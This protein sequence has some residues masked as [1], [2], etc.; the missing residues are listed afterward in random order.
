MTTIKILVG[1][2]L[3]VLTSPFLHSM[4]QS[5]TLSNYIELK[6]FFLEGAAICLDKKS[7]PKHFIGLVRHLK[8]DAV[9]QALGVD[10]QILTTYFNA[11]AVVELLELCTKEGKHERKADALI[12]S[13]KLDVFEREFGSVHI[14]KAI[15]Q[16]AKLCFFSG[17][18]DEK[19]E[20]LGKCKESVELLQQEGSEKLKGLVRLEKIQKLI[21]EAIAGTPFEWDELISALVIE[22][23]TV[24]PYFHLGN[25]LHLIKCLLQKESLT[26]MILINSIRWDTFLLALPELCGL[27]ERL[28]TGLFDK[29]LLEEQLKRFQNNQPLD[30]LALRNTIKPE[31][32]QRL[33]INPESV[34][35]YIDF[36]KVASG[37]AKLRNNLPAPELREVCNF[38]RI[39][40]QTGLDIQ[41][42]FNRDVPEQVKLCQLDSLTQVLTNR[43]FLRNCKLVLLGATSTAVLWLLCHEVSHEWME[44]FEPT[45][46]YT[47]WPACMLL[48]YLF[49]R[50]AHSLD[51]LPT[52]K[53]VS[54]NLALIKAGYMIKKQLGSLPTTHQTVL[55]SVPQDNPA[56]ESI[57]Q[58]L[59]LITPDQLLTLSHPCCILMLFENPSTFITKQE[60]FIECICSTD[61]GNIQKRVAVIVGILEAQSPYN[62]LPHA[63]SFT[64]FK[65]LLGIM[66]TVYDKLPHKKVMKL[67]K[68]RP[69]L[70]NRYP[71]FLQE[72]AKVKIGTDSLILIFMK[73]LTQAH[74]R[75][76]QNFIS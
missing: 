63:Q 8:G 61:P 23:F 71:E 20:L 36:A 75:E 2:L 59:F 3:C 26:P 70:L 42:F 14:K 13:C 56:Y 28:L 5:R 62:T 73:A 43:E 48:V 22:N 18:E 57:K 67:A 76:H 19:K 34:D 53:V 11:D 46:W 31:A 6:S 15:K 45:Q 4:A 65:N 24:S 7:D 37:L 52:Q 27:G 64:E 17:T 68:Y 54:T 30:P 41:A 74:K 12:R 33:H 29:E 21:D 49:Y 50:T 1:T 51:N 9:A 32:L 40:E 10:S 66:P 60:D 16:V 69:H 44:V 55:E 35:D 25:S 39:K 72:A 38:E 58:F 47:A